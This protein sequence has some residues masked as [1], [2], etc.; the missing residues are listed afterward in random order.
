MEDLVGTWLGLSQEPKDLSVVQMGLRAVLV[1]LVTIAAVRVGPMR[2]I[3][4]NTAL[5]FLLAVLLG[6][7]MSRAINGS[8]PMLPTLVAGFA[9]VAVHW[10]L[11]VLAFHVSPLGKLIKGKARP[12]VEDGRPLPGNLRRANFTHDDLLENLR[13]QGKTEDI[14]QVKVARLERNGQVSVIASDRPARIVEVR[15]EDGVQTVRLEIH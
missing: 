7:V 15:V 14:G 6:S 1:F 13:L 9:L 10:A 11:A 5:D 2:F 8:A 3:G 4:R 12:L